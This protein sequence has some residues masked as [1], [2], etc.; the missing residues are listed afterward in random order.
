MSSHIVV[1][2]AGYLCDK[3]KLNNKE[4]KKKREKKK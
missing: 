1:V 4:R 3:N 2:H